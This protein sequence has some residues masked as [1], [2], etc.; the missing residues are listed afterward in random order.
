MKKDPSLASPARIEEI[1]PGLVVDIRALDRIQKKT[2]CEVLL[3][4][5]EDLAYNST[6][7][8]DLKEYGHFPEHERPFIF[9]QIFLEIQREMN[10]LFDEI[11]KQIPLGITIV[12]MD[13]MNG[14]PM[15][16]GLLP[17]L[18]EMDKVE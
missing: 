6:Y 7:E 16:V 13:E 10:R 3:Y 1:I 18:D 14:R 11:L 9:L 2:G 5:E 8:K 15:V 17:F 4:F 12:R